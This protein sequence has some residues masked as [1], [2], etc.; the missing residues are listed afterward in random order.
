MVTLREYL[1]EKKILIEDIVTILER[2]CG[3]FIQELKKIKSGLLYRGTKRSVPDIKKIKVRKDRK[4]LDTPPEVHNHLD[5]EF[6]KKFGWFARS[7][8]V[9]TTPVRYDTG[10]YGDPYFFFPIGKYK[11]VWSKT[12]MDLFGYIESTPEYENYLNIVLDDD[13]GFDDEYEYEYGEGQKGHW[14]Y[15]GTDLRTRNAG[16]AIEDVLEFT[17]EVVSIADMEWVPDMDVNEYWIEKEKEAEN[18][19]EFLINRIMKT[20]TDKNL[21]AALSSRSEIVFKCK[22]YYLIDVR[23]ERNLLRWLQ[24]KSII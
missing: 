20:Y 10:D 6:K 24:G 15:E 4:P 3:P 17:G 2:D 5:N 18:E 8:G 1:T 12:V 9:F 14:E 21:K 11:F 7:E 22:E 13:E 16:D 19:W 23:W